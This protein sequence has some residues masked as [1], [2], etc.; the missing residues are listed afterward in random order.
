MFPPS[1]IKRKR[2][3]CQR[4]RKLLL[5]KMESGIAMVL[6]LPIDLTEVKRGSL[7]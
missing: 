7:M 1:I 5:R 2:W 3:I 6:E 4:V